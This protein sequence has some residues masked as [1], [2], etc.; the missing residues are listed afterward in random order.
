MRNGK[1]KR[2][3]KKAIYKTVL[4]KNFLKRRFKDKFQH[5]FL[6]VLSP[7]YSGSTLL[8]EALMRCKEVSCNN[9]LDNKE[10]QFLFEV[11]EEM[12][13]DPWNPDISFPW[14]KI[15]AVWLN[16][17]DPDCKVFLEKSPPNIIR[18]STLSQL[19]E[20]ANFIIVIRDPYATIEGLLRRSFK[21]AKSA[22]E[23]WVSCAS[24]QYKNATFL[25]NVLVLKYEEITEERESAERKV[26]SFIQEL[27]DFHLGGKFFAHNIQQKPAEVTNFNIEKINKLSKEQLKA[28]NSV[29]KNNLKYL[30]VFGYSII[31]S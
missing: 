4:I 30:N 8:T 15:K 19:F 12:R 6:F 31:E 3:R 27:D 25:S 21:D 11:R 17:W 28:I 16:Y 24:H 2:F 5:K 29:L 13:K 23:F 14:E 1:L 7:P 9:I 10:G 18:A 26:K 20:P 22:A